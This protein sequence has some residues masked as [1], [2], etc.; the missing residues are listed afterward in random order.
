MAAGFFRKNRPTCHRAMRRDGLP[1]MWRSCRSY[2]ERSL[3]RDPGAVRLCSAVFRT[4]FCGH[5]QWSL[6]TR[7]SRSRHFN[8]ECF[9]VFLWS[10]DYWLIWQLFRW[11]IPWSL[12]FNST[13]KSLGD[14]FADFLTLQR[15]ERFISIIFIKLRTKI[16]DVNSWIISLQIEEIPRSKHVIFFYNFLLKRRSGDPQFVGGR[17]ND[18]AGF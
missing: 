3:K 15:H 6:A 9:K 5:H 11:F 17:T 10:V 13:R 4:L 16:Y 1:S 8:N 14:Q 18:R 12:R 2:C 7:G